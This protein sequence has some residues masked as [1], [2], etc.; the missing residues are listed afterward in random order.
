MEFDIFLLRR[1]LSIP[2][3]TYLIISDYRQP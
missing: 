2:A 1:A 3:T